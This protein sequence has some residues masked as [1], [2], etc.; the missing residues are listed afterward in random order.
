MTGGLQNAIYNRLVA[1]AIPGVKG[2][3]DNPTQVTDPGNNALFPFITISEATASEWDDDTYTGFDTQAVIH[4]WSR[5]H[6]TLEAK[7]IQKAIYNAL[8]RYELSITGST[9]ITCE[10]QT[11]STVRDPDGVTI[12]GISQYRIISTNV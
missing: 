7:S 4:V 5:A 12:H 8:H 11:S 6:H 3:Y 2:I 10:H 9:L 1:V